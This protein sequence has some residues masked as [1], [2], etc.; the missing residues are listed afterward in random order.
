[1]LNKN[2]SW[3]GALLGEIPALDLYSYVLKTCE[4]FVCISVFRYGSE[5]HP[6]TLLKN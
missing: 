5:V 3:D 2:L 4:L 1:M 6:T